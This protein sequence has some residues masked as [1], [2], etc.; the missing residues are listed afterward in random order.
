MKVIL[1]DDEAEFVST[2]AER[3]SLRGIDADWTNRPEEAVDMIKAKCFDVAVLDVK[4]PRIGGIALKKRLQEAC[5]KLSFIF[6]TGHGSEE[7]FQAGSEEA[8][9]GQYLIKPVRLEDLMVRLSAIEKQRRK[10]NDND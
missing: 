4:M 10:E 3:L 6:L 2:L 5:P 1:V 8:G 9:T 7:A